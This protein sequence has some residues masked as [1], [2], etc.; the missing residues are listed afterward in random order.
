MILPFS[1]KD[2]IN[3]ASTRTIEIDSN[4]SIAMSSFC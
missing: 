2:V 4:P 3:N 1:I